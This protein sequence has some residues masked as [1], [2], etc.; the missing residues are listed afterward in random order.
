MTNHE[1]HKNFYTFVSEQYNCVPNFFG[2]NK[3]LTWPL[4]EEFSKWNLFLYIPQSGG[5]MSLLMKN[6]SFT[7]R[8]LD[9]LNH[10]LFPDIILAKILRVKNKH[11]HTINKDHGID[12]VADEN[13]PTE[14]RIDNNNEQTIL[15]ENIHIDNAHN[16]EEEI[17]NY[18]IGIHFDLP[19]PGIEWSFNF[20][21]LGSTFLNYFSQHYYSGDVQQP[22]MF[23]LINQEL[24]RPESAK[25]EM[26]IIIIGCFLHHVKIW[27]EFF[28]RIQSLDRLT[29]NEVLLLG[30]PN[31]ICIFGQ[32]NPGAGKSF[33]VH[34]ISN[35]NV[36][37][38]PNKQTT[39]KVAPTGCS[40]SVIF[41]KTYCRALHVPTGKK[42]VQIPIELK[43]PTR[44]LQMF[45]KDMNNLFCFIG[46]ETSMWNRSVLAWIDFLLPTYKEFIFDD[47]P[48]SWFPRNFGSIPI[49]F[50]LVSVINSVLFLKKIVT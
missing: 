11:R 39:L 20:H 8:L 37:L 13:L 21:D 2:Y 18:D 30:V 24:Y 40:A 16:N 49:L 36:C 25:G 29:F 17:E 31:C 42:L 14:N 4:T 27:Y 28:Q 1:V 33:V 50:F 23:G 32:G 43:N 44:K 35:I 3:N 12:F 7:K 41:G 46:D 22:S 34:T 6:A 47:I 45:I 10:P 5:N 26:Q 38:F 15:A 9:E 19:P 48:V